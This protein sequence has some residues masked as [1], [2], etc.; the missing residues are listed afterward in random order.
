MQ[1]ISFFKMATGYPDTPHIRVGFLIY[2]SY[3]D[4]HFG[5]QHLRHLFWRFWWRK[6]EW[7]YVWMWRWWL[8]PPLVFLA[9]YL[10]IRFV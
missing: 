7:R 5:A 8:G 9:V 2:S 10:W 3:L 1:K 4:W 6:F